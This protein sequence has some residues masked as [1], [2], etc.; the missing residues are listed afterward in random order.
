MTR[1]CPLRNAIVHGDRVPDELW[2]HGHSQLHHMHDR[3]ISTLRIVTA[4]EVGDDLL[5][6]RQSERTF[7]RA[8]D[9]AAA[10]LREARAWAGA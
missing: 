2:E 10:Y 8:A 5:R 4:N 1:L 3:L 6:M 7:A 9:E